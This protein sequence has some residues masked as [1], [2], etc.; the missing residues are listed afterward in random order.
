MKTKLDL[1]EEVRSNFKVTTDRKKL[2]AVQLDLLEQFIKVCKKYNLN[3]SMCGGSLLG[4]VRHDGYIPWDDDIDVM[5]LRE[6]YEKLCKVAD[7][8][9]KKPYFFATS[10]NDTKFIPHAQLKNLDTTAIDHADDEIEY[11]KCIFMDIFVFDK[12]PE[13]RL[14]QKIQ[15]TRMAIRRKY[16]NSYYFSDIKTNSFSG[17]IFRAFIRFTK[18][19]GSF[20]KKYNKYRKI[21]MKYD[22]TNSPLISNPE[23]VAAYEKDINLVSDYTDLIDHKFEYLTVKIPK[24]YD[25]ILT[26]MYGDYMKPVM[27]TQIHSIDYID[28]DKAYSRSK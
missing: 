14:K 19:F 2:W 5:M 23:F 26:K 1:K 7:K 11:N 3:Y 20:D 25:L 15:K 4:A 12:I 16:F 22:K 13:S 6:D 24:N 18:K 21:A 17:K 8:E 9:F 27:G 28:T 10:F